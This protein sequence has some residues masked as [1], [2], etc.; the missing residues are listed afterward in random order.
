[1][2]LLCLEKEIFDDEKFPLL[3]QA[4]MLHNEHFSIVNDDPAERKA[5]FRVEKR[6]NTRVGMFH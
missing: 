5:D 1:M 3:Y 2:L 4:Y 6:D